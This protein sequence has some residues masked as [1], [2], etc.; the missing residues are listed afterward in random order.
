MATF[1]DLRSFDHFTSQTIAGDPLVLPIGGRTYSFDPSKLTTSAYLTLQRVQTQTDEIA[2]KI[3]AGE[4]VDSNTIVM[5]DDQEKRFGHELL[6]DDVIAEL[7]AD[8]VLWSETQHVMTTVMSYYLYGEAA[9]LAIWSGEGNKPADPP[10]RAASTKTAGS[11][12]T[13]TKAK[14][15]SGGPRSSR[16]G[17]SSRRTSTAST[18]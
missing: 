14:P 6:G 17:G 9:A 8:G 4:K 7:A 16:N 5:N 15:R 12:T 3:D 2:R 13:R 10:A 1:P 18:K 11:S